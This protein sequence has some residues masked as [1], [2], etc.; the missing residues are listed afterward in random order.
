METLTEDHLIYHI[1]SYLRIH[2][3]IPFTVVNK[4]FHHLINKNDHL[5]VGGNENKLWPWYALK[6]TDLDLWKKKP[7]FDTFKNSTT[8]HRDLYLYL[9][10]KEHGFVLAYLSLFAPSG[11]ASSNGSDR[12]DSITDKSLHEWTMMIDEMIFTADYSSL[13]LYQ[14]ILVYFNHRRSGNHLD[15][16]GY[17]KSEEELYS[18]RLLRVIDKLDLKGHF[19]HF[20]FRA[21]LCSACLIRHLSLIA[22][23]MNR[24]MWQT[25]AA[26][27]EQL[28]IDPLIILRGLLILSGTYLDVCRRPETMC[29]MY[30]N[31][32]DIFVTLS[33]MRVN[34]FMQAGVDMSE[35]DEVERCLSIRRMDKMKVLKAMNKVM[36]EQ[37]A[38]RPVDSSQYYNIDN[39]FVHLVVRRRTGRINL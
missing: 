2:E 32:N 24:R 38:F 9:G 33:L 3:M 26:K 5:W 31:P 19:D 7:A 35:R 37:F 16:C 11:P 15:Q 13:M 14:K 34:V 1:V 30:D 8:P 28:E 39:S 20:L 17:F 12:S 4:H 27:N 23:T 21:R 29:N 6:I 18:A 25:E 22:Y 10:K 36:F